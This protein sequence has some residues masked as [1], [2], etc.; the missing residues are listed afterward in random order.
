MRHGL[1]LCGLGA[2]LCCGPAAAVPGIDEADTVKVNPVRSPESRKHKAVL[3]G[4][5]DPPPSV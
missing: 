1:L 5:A 4:L 2:L 3:A